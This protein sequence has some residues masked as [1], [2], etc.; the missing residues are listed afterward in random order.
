VAQPR[1]VLVAEPGLLTGGDLQALALQRHALQGWRHRPGEPR[2]PE[3]PASR[4]D[5]AWSL[6]C[7]HVHHSVA[8]GTEEPDRHCGHARPV[9][10]RAVEARPLEA[11]HRCDGERARALP[12]G[13]V[14]AQL[15]VA[16]PLDRA[17]PLP[18]VHR[19][20][21]DR[22]GLV[23]QRPELPAERGQVDRLVRAVR[24]IGHR[25][26]ARLVQRVQLVE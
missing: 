3:A 18:R 14:E 13:D 17:E 4:V 23:Q 8:L 19:L 6:C 1:V 16:V 10:A 12:A 15:G 25:V 24:V 5:A 20:H 26:D 2:Q 9:D 7:R 11:Q 22:R 21:A